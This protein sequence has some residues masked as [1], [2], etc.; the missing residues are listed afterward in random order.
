MQRPL[1]TRALL[2][3]GDRRSDSP[4]IMSVVGPVSA[5]QASKIVAD[6]FARRNAET[7]S[8]AQRRDRVA[9]EGVDRARREGAAA[10]RCSLRRPTKSSRSSRSWGRTVFPALLALQSLA[11][12]ALAWATYHRLGRARL[13]APLEPLREFRFNDQLVWGLIVGLT[14]VLLPTLTPLRDLG[15]ESAGVL[16]CAVRDPR[17]RRAHVVHG[18]R[19]PRRRARGGLRP[20]LGAGSQRF[21]ALAF[22]TLGRRSAGAGLGRYLGRLAQP[23]AL[24]DVI[25]FSIRFSKSIGVTHGNHSPPGA[26]RTSASRVTW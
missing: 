25:R 3:L 6:E 21:A 24:D 17:P 22:M 19:E 10:C 2:A 20:A 15:Q 8:D 12:L 9:S 5:S 23:R 4:T 26:S 13:G 14:I 7:M 1:F 16:R 11:A 18:A